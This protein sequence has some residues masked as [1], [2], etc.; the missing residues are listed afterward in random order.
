MH[1]HPKIK[2]R[3]T[4]TQVEWLLLNPVNVSFPVTCHSGPPECRRDRVCNILEN[5]KSLSWFKVQL[6][7]SVTTRASPR[8]DRPSDYAGNILLA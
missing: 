6:A 2:S 4:E 5:S 7:H 1:F 8:S 3:Y